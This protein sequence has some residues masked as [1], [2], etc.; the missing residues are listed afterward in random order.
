M[1]RVV[2]IESATV[3]TDPLT[4]T[5]P[6]FIPPIQEG[7]I[8]SDEDS[9]LLIMVNDCTIFHYVENI[10]IRRGKGSVGGL[11]PERKQCSGAHPGY[12]GLALSYLLL[13]DRDTS[14]VPTL[15]S[16][17]ESLLTGREDEGGSMKAFDDVLH[18]CHLE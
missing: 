6:I 9:E 7:A 11:E 10:H 12:H 8:G 17:L 16:E 13:L 14:E 15:H 4:S 5:T 18:V 2:Q 3:S 1:A